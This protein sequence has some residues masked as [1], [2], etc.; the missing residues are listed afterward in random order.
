MPTTRRQKKARKSRGI[1]MLSDI[2]NLDIMLGENHFNRNERDESVSSNFGRRPGSSSADELENNGENRYSAIRDTGPSSNADYGQIST[3]GNSSAEINKLSSELNSRLSR[4]LDDM[5]CSVNSQIQKAISDA[6]SNQ[7]LPQI[8]SALSAGS[9]HLTQNRW[10]VPS[11]RPEVNSEGLQNTNPKDSSAS[12][13]NCNRRNDGVVD[14]NAYDNE[15]KIYAN[16]PVSRNY[17]V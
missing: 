4:E 5:M 12:K 16:I 6:V 2:E 9:G 13:P 8:Q 11:E 17:N 10:D 15:R 7:V 14:T 3:G 1:E